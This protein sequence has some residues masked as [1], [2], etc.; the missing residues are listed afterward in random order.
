M[1]VLDSVAGFAIWFVATIGE[2]EC[3]VKVVYYF[4]V[5]FYCDFQ[6]VVFEHLAN[7]FFSV[8]LGAC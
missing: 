3:N 4:F 1:Y 8:A 5:G 7:L 6:A 2:V